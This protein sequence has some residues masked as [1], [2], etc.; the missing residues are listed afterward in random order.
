MPCI[1][2]HQGPL[3]LK[4]T[5]NDNDEECTVYKD[6]VPA[7]PT[8]NL[9]HSAAITTTDTHTAMSNGSNGGARNDTDSIVINL[10]KCNTLSGDI[11][12]EFYTKQKMTRKKKTLFGFWFNTFFESEREN[13]GMSI[14]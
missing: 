10:D 2:S 13:D 5:C 9:S 14:V 8:N 12:I 6:E 7:T 1:S 4:I 11:K 3:F